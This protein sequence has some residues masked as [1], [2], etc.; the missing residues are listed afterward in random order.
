MRVSLIC[1]MRRRLRQ[2]DTMFP[3]PI[4][5]VQYI[6]WTPNIDI[7]RPI[8]I[9]DVRYP[10]PTSDIYF[11]HRYPC[12]S[13]S[14]NPSPSP[15]PCPSRSQVLYISRRRYRMSDIYWMSDIYIG[16]PIQISEILV[17]FCLKRRPMLLLCE[18][19]VLLLLTS[20]FA[21]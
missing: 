7:R 17:S 5:D 1:C 19:A 15:S 11:R 2:N 8:S 10:Y 16:H 3:K 4:S 13:P 14:P 21:D 20:Y 18:L 12:P 6:Y 9:S